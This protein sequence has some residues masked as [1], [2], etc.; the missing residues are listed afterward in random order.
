MAWSPDAHQL[1]YLSTDKDITVIGV[2]GFQDEVAGAPRLFPIVGTE[3]IPYA[4]PSWSPDGRFIAFAAYIS[5]R[6]RWSQELFVLDVATG[7]VRRLTDNNCR[8]DMP[9]WSPDGALI[10]FTSAEDGY[11]EVHLLEVATGKRWQITHGVIGY[12]PVWSPD[13]AFL[14]FSSNRDIGS[15]LYLIRPDGSDLRRLTFEHNRNSIYPIW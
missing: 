12:E 10:A 3:P 1:A 2:V 5:P 15:D 9:S 14:A 6:N 11:N 8:N 7:A 4:L 13:G